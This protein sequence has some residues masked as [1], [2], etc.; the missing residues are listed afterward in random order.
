[1]AW[2]HGI[3]LEMHRVGNRG[4]LASFVKNLVSERKIQVRVG[5]S[6]STPMELSEGTPQGSILSCTLFLM[7]INNISNR[8]PVNVYCTLYVDDFSIYS[9]GQ[10]PN[11]I[12]RHLQV[13]LNGL[14]RWGDET[15]FQ[16]SRNKNTTMHICRKNRCC[17][18]VSHLTLY[19]TALQCVQTHKFLGVTIDH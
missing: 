4:N 8:L 1:M 14:Q 12:E 6:L 10:V 5:S 13:A 15:G 3:I 9:S 11:I 19:G 18:A 16:F 2:R 7:A 17:R